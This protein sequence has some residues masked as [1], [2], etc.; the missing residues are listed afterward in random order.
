MYLTHAHPEQ[1]GGHDGE[2]VNALLPSVFTRDK[3]EA[4]AT[5]SGEG[6]RL[7]ARCSLWWSHTPALSGDR[8]A[9]VGV[10]GHYAAA[11]LQA[12]SQLLR[13][14]CG[15]LRSAGCSVAIGPMNGNTWRDYRVILDDRDA[16]GFFLEPDSPAAWALHFQHA[17]FELFADYRSAVCDD[18]TMTD[19]RLERV[20]RR[21]SRQGVHLRT[22]RLDDLGDDLRAIHA[23]ALEAFGGAMLYHPVTFVDFAESFQPILDKIDPSLILLAERRGETVGF[24]FGIPDYRQAVLPERI[25]TMVLKT[26]AVKPERSLAGLGA[27]LMQRSHEAARERG[28]RRVIHAMMHAANH[29]IIALSARYA[30]PMRRYGLFARKLH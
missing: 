4:Y 11:D 23:V 19:P 18:L 12:G 5:W 3:A 27:L 8:T 13:R 20:G 29:R 1:S 25:D 14:A 21:L 17:G 10:I 7:L 15:T 28:M 24:C 26:L 2:P 6:E 9:K 30:Q 16:A 22:L